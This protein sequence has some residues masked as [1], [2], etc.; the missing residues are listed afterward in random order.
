M[1]SIEDKIRKTRNL[2]NNVL[3]LWIERRK[4]IDQVEALVSFEN[5]AKVML[6]NIKIDDDKFT[7]LIEKLNQN[8]ESLL[9]EKDI[10]MALKTHKSQK[11]K[12][13]KNKNSIDQLVN[14]ADH[15]TI[16]GHAYASK[17]RAWV[18]SV[19][20]RQKNVNDKSEEYRNLL[21]IR[22][23]N[24]GD[25]IYR[26]F[27]RHAEREEGT[28]SG[29]NFGTTKFNNTEKV[30]L[31]AKSGAGNIKIR[32]QSTN[33]AG[34]RDQSSKRSQISPKITK[35]QNHKENLIKSQNNSPNNKFVDSTIMARQARNILLENSS[36]NSTSVQHQNNTGVKINNEQRQNKRKISE[37]EISNSVK[38]TKSRSG[39]GGGLS[40]KSHSNSNIVNHKEKEPVS[41][42]IVTAAEKEIEGEK[43]DILSSSDSNTSSD[44]FSQMAGL[45]KL[46]DNV[47]VNP[48]DTVTNEMIKKKAF[49]VKELMDTEKT[50][51]ED[52][53]R[54]IQIYIPAANNLDKSY[55]NFEDIKLSDVDKIILFS[56]IR[57]ILNFHENHFFKELKR[58][59]ATGDYDDIP[60]AFIEW[61]QSFINLYVQYSVNHPNTSKILVRKNMTEYFNYI[62][63]NVGSATTTPH[64]IQPIQ[65]L[66]IKPVQRMMK[67]SL[68]LKDLKSCLSENSLQ[69][70]AC[71]L[72][73]KAMMDVPKRAND[74]SHLKLIDYKSNNLYKIGLS[75]AVISPDSGE[76]QT[77]NETENTL[78]P[79]ATELILQMPISVFPSSNQ[80]TK[81]LSKTRERHLFLFESILMIAKKEEITNNHHNNHNGKDEN[82]SQT[83]SNYTNSSS[84]GYNFKYTIK[85]VYPRSQLKI[86]LQ[87]DQTSA[88]EQNK[89]KANNN[90]D[91][92]SQFF[93]QN[94]KCYK[95]RLDNRKGSDKIVIGTSH[96]EMFGVLF[97]ELR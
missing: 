78:I 29:I 21:E 1:N 48:D 62:Q 85:S 30:N 34:L 65:S 23:K 18:E 15:L 10:L 94:M 22:C 52:L 54:C 26:I 9:E 6:E 76:T 59:Y 63:T 47:T 39:S 46:D 31:R 79:S 44:K 88:P 11:K 84:N 53:N 27:K 75:N 61:K 55:K 71:D 91:F 38:N 60:H 69:W 45:L 2:K 86:I 8:N 41:A 56:N 95:L 87:N 51:I 4:Q 3:G 80:I 28:V 83:S 74:A 70:K 82:S 24:S 19:K 77:D 97:D 5:S 89:N 67:Y 90:N 12:F 40:L 13:L 35:S 72:A 17:Y 14:L 20:Q 66:L 43:L 96:A 37:S 68:L 93:D 58:L 16:S 57:E 50:Y 92:T 42:T 64:Q 73:L 36:E 7:E 81:L 32:P 33:L 25:N 49:I